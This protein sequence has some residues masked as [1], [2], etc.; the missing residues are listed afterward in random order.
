MKITNLYKHAD[1]KFKGWF[2]FIIALYV[3][4]CILIFATRELVISK[5][6]RNEFICV[7]YCHFLV[8]QCQK[9]RW[10]H[11]KRA[12]YTNKKYNRDCARGKVPLV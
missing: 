11:R 1:E 8:S 5:V 9:K 10:C 12:S 2:A 4:F 3:G 7:I 6:D